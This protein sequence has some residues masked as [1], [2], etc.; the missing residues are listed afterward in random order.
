[1][2]NNKEILKNLISIDRI[3]E[4]SASDIIDEI[5]SNLYKKEN[6]HV[7]TP[8]I[9][10]KI[11]LIIK[12]IILLIDFDIEVNMNGILGFLENSTGLFLEDTIDALE[13]IGANEDTKIL[14]NIKNIMEKYNIS[15]N[16]LRENVNSGSLY[17]ISSFIEI[18][19]D[20]YDDMADEISMEADKLYISDPNR[21]VFDNL[22]IYIKKH[23]KELINE[24]LR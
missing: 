22:E 10:N 11:P 8:N 23:K 12:H 5:A 3:E 17:E 7:R 21:N 6:F 14:K 1:M 4:M 24:L 2:D 20:E 15:T 19:G 18:H 16:D 13:R 9:I